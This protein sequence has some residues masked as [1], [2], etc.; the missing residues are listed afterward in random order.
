MGSRGAKRIIRS[1]GVVFDEDQ[2]FGDIEIT[3]RF[4]E[5]VDGVVDLTPTPFLM[6]TTGG[7]GGQNDPNRD[8]AQGLPD[9]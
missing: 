9:E 7:E 3:E 1:M 4:K 6:Q 5:V 2:F 8:E